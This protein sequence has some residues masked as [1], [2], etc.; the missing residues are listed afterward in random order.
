MLCAAYSFWT[1]KLSRVILLGA[2]LLGVGLAA[3]GQSV[4]L[5][6][7]PSTNS[8]VAGY[9]VYFGTQ[10]QLYTNVI[11]VGNV[12]N[13]LITNLAPGLTYY[14]SAKSHDSSTNESDFAAETAFAVPLPVVVSNPPP[15]LKALANMTINRNSGS[16]SI[17]LAGITPG[18]TNGGPI[19]VT[20]TSSNPNLINPTVTYK[21]PKTTGTLTFKPSMNSTGTVTITVTVNNGGTNNNTCSKTFT[22]TVVA[23]VT[24]AMVAAVPRISRQPQ[25]TTISPGKVALLTVGVSGKAPFHYQWQCNGTN[26]PGATAS[27]LYLRNFT[28]NQAGMY[29]VQISNNYGSTNSATALLTVPGVSVASVG[30]AQ[31][32]PIVNPAAALT[33]MPATSR[34]EFRFQVGGVSGSNYVVE[35][36]LDLKGWAPVCTNQSPFVYTETNAAAYAQR[37]YRARYLP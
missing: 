34:G 11:P 2:A 4:M 5:S 25:G 13:V 33:A 14:F 17:T 23:P 10:S 1:Q 3:E 32:I 21:N 8:G 35:A 19:T 31:S 16:Q 6:W 12:T 7:N 15:T 29:S 9:N 37:F 36:S 26:L 20:A 18:I 27:F 28:A 24:Q 22:V 30:T